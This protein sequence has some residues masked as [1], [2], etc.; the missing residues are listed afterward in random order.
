[1]A[2]VISA[3][4]PINEGTDEGECNATLTI[5]A[6][7][8]SDNCTAGT[9]TGTRSDNL[10]LTDPF[11]TGT[12]TITWNYSDGI[13]A[14]TAVEQVVTVTDDEAPVIAAV[15]PINEGTDEGECNATLTIVAPS[16]SDNCTAG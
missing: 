3:V 14:A 16:A 9:A 15:S 6:P 12:T 13:N 4:S 11:P 10:A 8:A 7:S 1:E 2:P 5:V